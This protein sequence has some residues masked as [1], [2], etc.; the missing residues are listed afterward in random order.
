M[1]SGERWAKVTFREVALCFGQEAWALVG[2]EKKD[3][4][5]K[6]LKDIHCSLTQLGFSI[7]SAAVLSV[8]VKQEDVTT[9]KT[10]PCTE[11]EEG[12]DPFHPDLLFWI[13]QEEDSQ[14][15][16]MNVTSRGA[17]RIQ[18]KTSGQLPDQTSM[19]FQE[20]AVCFCQTEWTSFED[21]TKNLYREVLQDI[22]RTLT[23]LGHIILNPKT[24]IRMR[25][26][27]EQRERGLQGNK[28]CENG[29][30]PGSGIHNDEAAPLIREEGGS[31]APPGPKD[32][33]SAGAGSKNF[34]LNVKIKE[35]EDSDCDAAPGA[36]SEDGESSSQTG[37]KNL[38]LNVKIKEEEDSDR[39]AA[40]G[41]QSGDRESSSQAG[42]KNLELNVKV[43]E[44]EDSD[45]DAAPGAQSGDGESSSQAD[46]KNLELNVKVKEEE[47]SDRDAAPGAQ[48]GDGESSSQAGSKNLE[49]N[50]KVKEEEDSDRDAAPGAQSRDEESSS[51][52]GSKNLELNVK[53]KEEEDSDRDAA[54][55][56]QSGDGESSSQA[57]SKNL[58][59][60]VKVKEEEDS[61]RGAA[62][63]A[64]SG[65]GESSS[66]AGSKNLEL[67]VKV[68]EEEDS[69]RDA[70]PGAQSR[71][72]ESSSQAGSKNLELNVKVKEE[73][74][75]DRDAAPG[76]QSGD[77]ESSSQA[78][79]KNLELNVKVKEEED[80]D[81][82]AAPGAQSG[83]GESS[84]Q[85]DSKNLELN[86]KVKEEED[87]DRD[88]APGAQSGDGE[89]S[90]QAD[91]KNLELNVKVKEEEDSDRDAA[92]GAQSGDG[93]SSSQAGSVVPDFSVA[94]ELKQKKDRDPG[95]PPDPKTEETQR[96]SR[97][98]VPCFF[99]KRGRPPLYSP[100]TARKRRVLATKATN[101]ARIS[102]GKAFQDWMALRT[103]TGFSNEE[104]T[105]FLINTY[106]KYTA[107]T[108]D[109]DGM[110]VTL[111][112][113]FAEDST[114][115][116]DAM[117]TEQMKDSLREEAKTSRSHQYRWKYSWWS[118]M[119]TVPHN[120]VVPRVANKRGRPPLYT[121]EAALKR[122]LFIIEKLKMTRINIGKAFQDW[123]ALKIELDLSHEDM[124]LFL[125]STYRKYTASTIDK[126]GIE[127]TL[128]PD[129]AEDSTDVKDATDTEQMEGVQV[130]GESSDTVTSSSSEEMEIASSPEWTNDLSSDWSE[131]D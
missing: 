49:L 22:H 1:M 94:P 67:N 92:P 35:E 3:V 72:E 118:P 121:P 82:G 26:K 40:P 109:K 98:G 114:D 117:N 96:S 108:I 29:S 127:V 28:K 71:D 47:D 18:V 93:E 119:Q 101:M 37:S 30:H 46:S 68:K 73:E 106:R 48:S 80:S 56:A 100:E 84:S 16:D 60:N 45:R 88:A 97:I 32:L 43:K 21:R 11:K 125:I 112:P 124:A 19:T 83:D 33:T 69:D 41:A 91:S 13:K 39:D 5:R 89:S 78:G 59:L 38:E 42:S 70:A 17:G 130:T 81:R 74:D 131:S 116:K 61:D 25:E 99:N 129:F 55:G 90:S 87:S 64:Q 4:Y 52:A 111:G 126:D 102:I 123:K 14:S 6:V 115:V 57:G 122:R 85:A 50:V 44:E 31:S 8:S 105:F 66:Q 120:P 7:V 63:G 27:E 23:Q 104:M 54:P 110:E 107:G 113:D 77:G 58:E 103:Q 75:S 20:V 62:P 34:E 51:Q 86:V 12:S 36:Q 10:A 65:D 128:D 95:T 79:S 76:A 24:F 9:V 15:T 53:V 2:E